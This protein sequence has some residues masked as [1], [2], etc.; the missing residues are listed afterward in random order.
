MAR[1]DVL[2]KRFIKGQYGIENDSVKITHI[3][4]K[5]TGNTQTY[6]YHYA[7]CI[8]SNENDKFVVKSYNI[9]DSTNKIT[10]ILIRQLHKN[11]YELDGIVS[12][13][14]IYKK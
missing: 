8:A 5:S 7:T 4:F 2:V 6:L 14:L 12:D 1:N 11:G 10:D 13:Y 3:D 9:S